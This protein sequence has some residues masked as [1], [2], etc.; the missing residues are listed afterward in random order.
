MKTIIHLLPALLA[1]A[2]PLSIVAELAGFNPPATLDSL[3][4]F[5]GWVVTLLITSAVADYGRPPRTLAATREVPVA[6]AEHP[7]AA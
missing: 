1:V 2:V 7:L 6:K 5:C 4:L 3:H